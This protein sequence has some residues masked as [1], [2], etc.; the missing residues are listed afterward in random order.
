MATQTTAVP[1]Q[2]G[3]AELIDSKQLSERWRVPESWVRTKS[4][5]R[6]AKEN[7]I[8]HVRL[9]RYVRFQPGLELEAWL[10]RQRG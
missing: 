7:R 1:T 3:I 6:T 2:S 8:P 5:L 4:G 9:G 10:A